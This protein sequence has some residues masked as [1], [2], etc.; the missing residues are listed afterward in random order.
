[1]SVGWLASQSMTVCV[2]S[3]FL[4]GATRVQPVAH[5]VAGEARLE[6]VVGAVGLRAQVGGDRA[7]VLAREQPPEG[8]AE[9]EAV[10]P[11]ER[12]RDDDGREV[13]LRL[14]RL[15]GED[16]PEHGR[17]LLPPEEEAVAQR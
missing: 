3:H 15:L 14:S 16:R 1:M 5:A 17:L 4:A 7:L 11:R 6:Q 2:A 12:A 9:R 10:R 13:V 8:G